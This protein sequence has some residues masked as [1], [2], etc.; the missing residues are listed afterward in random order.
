MSNVVHN[1]PLLP[2]PLKDG[3]YLS[4]GVFVP[5]TLTWDRVEKLSKDRLCAFGSYT[6]SHCRL[7]FSEH[8][9]LKYKSSE[10]KKEI[11]SHIGKSVEHL[12]C[13]LWMEDRRIGCRRG[14]CGEG[15]I[16]NSHDFMGRGREKI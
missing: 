8:N 1:L 5:D 14:V 2:L 11:E 9:W 12:S 4:D 13:P 10:I 15:R 7:S 6:M 3:K 16:Q